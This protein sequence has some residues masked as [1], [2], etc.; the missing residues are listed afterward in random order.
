MKKQNFTTQSMVKTGMFTAV[1][2]VLSI[3]QIPMPTGVPLTLQTF[4]MA[5]CG[6]VLGSWSGTGAVALYLAVGTVGVPVF[7]GMKGGIA[8]LTGPTGGFLFGFLFLAWLCG[9][10][11]GKNKITAMGAGLIGLAF[12]HLLGMLGFVL[13]AGVSLPQAFVTVSLPYLVKDALSVA[14][15]MQVGAVLRNRLAGYVYQ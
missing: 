6:Y 5:L 13:A 2:A 14:V 9:A 12:C 15:A 7:A 3:L 10:G 4:A 8:V 1:L 11:V